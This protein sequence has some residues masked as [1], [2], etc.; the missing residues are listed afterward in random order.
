M[1]TFDPA[2]K[3]FPDY[4][5]GVTKTIWEDRG[6]DTLKRY[7]GATMPVRSPGSIVVGNE[8]VIAATLTTL[9]EFPDRRLLGE[10]VI[11][12]EG[13]D[14][15]LLSSHRILSTATH[16]G[17]VYGPA[18]GRKVC[19][20]IIADCYARADVIEDEWLIRDQGAIV[21]QLGLD[22]MDHARELIAREG[23]PENATRPYLPENDVP[24]PYTGHGNSDE[25]GA[26]Y[27]DV[28][29]RLMEAEFSLVPQ[30]YDRAVQAAL[31]GGDTALS[32]D[33]VDRFWL[34]LRASLPSARFTIHH[35]IGRQE[36]M[37]PPRAAVRWSL[38]G[39]HDGWGQLGAPTGARVHVMGVSHAEFGP[40]GL[41]REFTLF[42]ETAIA[43]QIL[44]QTG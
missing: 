31:P 3:D 43:R 4:I 1:K 22:P 41:R 34:G 36:P 10:D 5:L 17:G 40:W 2:W 19:Y 12:C 39:Q 25:W 13:N 23:G 38:D 44:L 33:G 8:G 35:V 20:R 37:M 24:G 7:Y 15:G 42:D 32:H 21:R 6:I 27:A 26:H 29:S 14:D 28:L 16:A 30:V 9:A 18:T 11:W